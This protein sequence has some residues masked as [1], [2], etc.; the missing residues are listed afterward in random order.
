MSDVAIHRA[1]LARF[2]PS[3]AA[4]AAM[5]SEYMP[6]FVNGI[7]D[8]DG[9]ARVHEARMVVKAHRVAVEKMRVELKADALAYGRA[10]DGEAKRLAALLEPIETHLSEEENMV[11]EEKARIEQEAEDAKRA[12]LQIRLDAFAACGAVA[13]PLAV[14]SWDDRQYQ[15]ALSTAQ[16]AA[17]ERAEQA[18]KAQAE[19]EA[20]AA[21]ERADRAAE[22]AKQQAREEALAAER[23][24][25]AVIRREQEAEAAR[26]AAER[27]RLAEAA[28]TQRR[29]AELEAAKAQAAERAR[30]ETE[31][32]LAREKAQA[33]AARK[34]EVEEKAREEAER[35]Y[36]E[37]VLALADQVAFLKVPDGPRCEC[38][39]RIL[40]DAAIGIRMVM[41][42]KAKP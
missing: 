29:S 32:R 40:S 27:E 42:K 10:V 11:A 25:L 18:A 41:S 30:E 20:R 8:A 5:A 17:R 21:Q 38:V 24:S 9:L 34:A 15:L 33:E 3:D 35:P 22:T 12:A 13:N 37:K 36:R 28:A 16:A 2:S 6:L 19:A 31:A 1:E 4:I 7:K 23:E 26:L 14:A 39:R